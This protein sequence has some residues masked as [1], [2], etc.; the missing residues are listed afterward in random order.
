MCLMEKMTIGALAKRAGVNVETIR[1]YQRRQL[2]AQPKRPQA[3]FRHYPAESVKRVQFIKRAQALGFTLD[4]IAGLL[5]LDGSRACEET[6]EIAVHKLQLIE[7]RLADLKK[8]R[9]ALSQL[10]RACGASPAGKECPII[11]QLTHE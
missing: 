6:R 5:A 4:E 11:H 7:K 1:Y 2:L 9:K 10:V 3:G 8:I